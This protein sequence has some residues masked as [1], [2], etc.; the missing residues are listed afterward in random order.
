M[1]AYGPNVRV[2]KSAREIPCFALFSALRASDP[3]FQIEIDRPIMQNGLAGVTKKTEFKIAQFTVAPFPM[4][5]SRL[6][7][8]RSYALFVV[9]G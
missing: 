4:L 5:E 8:A 9:H 3:I 6:G 2:F 1:A 7:R